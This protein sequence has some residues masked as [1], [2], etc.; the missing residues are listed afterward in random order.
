MNI[1][2]GY[3]EVI[4]EVNIQIHLTE[5]DTEKLCITQ[6]RSHDSN[7]IDQLLIFNSNKPLEELEGTSTDE[8]KSTIHIVLPD[9]KTAYTLLFQVSKLFEIMKMEEEQPA[10]V[11]DELIE[12]WT[13]ELTPN[14]QK[15]L[16]ESDLQ[17][18][19]TQYLINQDSQE[20]N[21]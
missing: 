21:S 15:F 13:E 18:S 3:K 20:W 12:T 1:F 8:L 11:I 6:G 2:L 14:I 4:E 10:I 7:K 16:G 9:L 17:G 5:E 19:L